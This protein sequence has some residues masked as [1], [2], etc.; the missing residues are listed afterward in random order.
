MTNIHQELSLQQGQSFYT[1]SREDAYFLIQGSVYIYL[2]PLGESGALRRLFLAEFKEGEVFPG[3][4]WKD[5]EGQNWVFLVLA[6]AETKIRTL[7]GANTRVLQKTFCQT[8]EISKLETEGFFNAL[9]DH[10]QRKMLIPEKG[11]FEKNRQASARASQE[12][13][14]T[15]GAVFG[16]EDLAEALE[17]RDDLYAAVYM[18]CKET[19]IP[20]IAYD[21]LREALGYKKA[22]VM[23][24]ARCSNF[25]CREIVLEEGWEE[26]DAGPVIAFR[27]E[28]QTPVACIPQGSHHY[29][30]YDPGSGEKRTLTAELA[31]DLDIKGYGL[32]RPLPPQ[33]LSFKDLRPFIRQ[34]I[35]PV[36][37]AWAAG[38]AL[39]ISLLNLLVPALNQA[40]YDRY[41][42]LSQFSWVLEIGLLVGCFM[43]GNV[44]FSIVKA[45]SLSRI[46]SHIT[47]DLQSAMYARIFKLP[48]SAL[49]SMESGDLTQRVASISTMASSLSKSFFS[50]FFSAA[51]NLIFLIQ[52]FVFSPRLALVGLGL[53]LSYMLISVPIFLATQKHERKRVQLDARISARIQQYLG[54]MAKLRMAGAEKRALLQYLKPYA[55]KQEVLMKQKK[56]SALGDSLDLIASNLFTLCL[57]AIL[58]KSQFILSFGA[59]M[60]FNAAFGTV[61]A[62]ALSVLSS[63]KEYTAAKPG[64]KLLTPLLQNS[65]EVDE[66]REMPGD[67]GGRIEVRN[68]SF[69]YA[70][71]G[72]LVLD[73]LSLT[74][75]AGEYLAIVGASGCGKSTLLKCLLGFEKPLQGKIYYDNLD[76]EQV[77]KQELRKKMGVVLQNDSTISG[78]IIDNI[79]LT[80]PDASYEQVMATVRAV[81]L[82][83]DIKHM[84]M[85]I[86]TMLSERGDTISGGQKQRITIAR[87]IINQPAILFFDEATSAL[88]NVTQDKVIHTLDHLPATRIVIAH[89]LSTILKCDRIIVM[90]Q[91]HIVES[92]NYD[93]LMARQGLFYDLATR[94]I[95]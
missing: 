54:G 95:A 78:S 43:L 49:E 83:E 5:N 77:N 38:L 85:G 45:L 15:L 41:I 40:I 91:G 70:A 53:L 47:N 86:R 50:S 51:F 82:E 3:Y 52:L 68:L 61:C 9:I 2:L 55:E 24:I 31:A 92:G 74:V 89:R 48:Q 90:D 16:V 19:G 62:A 35:R 87:A 8:C 32:Y 37:I 18:L 80:C 60:A 63:W 71:E 94:Q 12:I 56:I 44:A 29:L 7:S 79:R 4:V 26:T 65:P 66:A 6:R 23:D 58:I 93:E 46:Y 59:F 25:A 42:P 22:G 76:L 13:R 84:P 75:E 73:N 11:L 14:S 1:P 34:S 36:D 17:A 72:P 10:Y 27:T 88:D 67:L 39:T 21:K 81:G 69:R 20:C 30:L 57:Y 64:L 28:R 33:A